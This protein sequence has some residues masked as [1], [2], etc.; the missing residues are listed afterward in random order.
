MKFLKGL[1][2]SLLS[3][4]LFLSLSAFGMVLT[5]NQ[6]VLNPDFV[7]SQ[8]DKL[9][10]SSLAGEFISEQISG[11][12]PLDNQLMAEILEDTITDLEPWIKEQ[13]NTAIYASYDYLTGKSQ[14]LNIV[15][16]TAELKETLKDSIKSAFLEALPPE[17]AG[18][19]PAMIDAAFNEYYQQYSQQ[20]P[21]TIE[22]NESMLGSEVMSSLEQARQYIGYIQIAYKALIVL[23]LVLI[24]LIVLIHRKVR[25]STRQTGITFLTYGIPGFASIFILKNYAMTQMAQLTQFNL[26]ASFQAWLPQ[27]VD[28]L[29]APLEMFSLG[30][31]I[32]GAVLLIVSFVYKPQES[33][34]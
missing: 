24:G 26:P 23:I 1:A 2:L 33:S 31:L 29:L 7:A 10:I 16:P 22:I 12:I 15:I 27:L 6:T 25:G 9:D 17:L 30:V 11:Q 32:C 34:Y 13:A 8:V 14:S 3:L 4:I 21:A 28:D 20:I 19:P 5:I 18:V